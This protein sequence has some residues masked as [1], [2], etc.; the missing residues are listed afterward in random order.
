MADS[1]CSVVSGV[2]LMTLLS[3]YWSEVQIAYVRMQIRELERFHV[4]GERLFS[5]EF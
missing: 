3:D 5:F 2:E 4:E 1:E